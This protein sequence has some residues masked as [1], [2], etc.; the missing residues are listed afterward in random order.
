M[1]R[2]DAQQSRGAQPALGGTRGP[3]LEQN[4]AGDLVGAAWPHRRRDGP[5]LDRAGTDHRHPLLLMQDRPRL[6]LEDPDEAGEAGA[7]GRLVADHGDLQRVGA[8]AGQ[9]VVDQQRPVV[10][11]VG[12]EA[13]LVGEQVGEALAWAATSSPAA[14]K[15]ESEASSSSAPG[16]SIAVLERL[17]ASAACA[18]SCCRPGEESSRAP[19]AAA[20][21]DSSGRL[22]PAFCG[23]AY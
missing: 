11:A 13:E 17:E 3:H 12:A 2:K 22:R 19:S 20:S 23:S 14:P 9:R 21:R 8:A 10:V 18:W 4:L 1:G 7:A 15:S 6:A 16:D 5:A